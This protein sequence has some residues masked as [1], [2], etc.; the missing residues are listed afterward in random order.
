MQASP[1]FVPT[2]GICVP[3]KGRLWCNLPSCP[4]LDRFEKKR[5]VQKLFE[6][7]EFVG[8][9]PPS[10]FVSWK[11]YPNVDIAPLSPPQIVE[12]AAFLDNPEQWY[13]LPSSEI[14]GFRQQLFRS[15]KKV[16][17][18]SASNPTYDVAAIQEIAM[19]EKQVDLDVNLKDKP[20]LGS[21]FSDLFAPM[22]PSAAMEKFSFESNP[23]IPAK[24]D[25]LVSDTDAKSAVA[26]KELYTDGLP[27][28][29]L[30]KLLSAGTLGVKKNR[31][32]VPTRWSIVA[33]DDTVSKQLLEKVKYLPQLSEIRLFNSNYL[34]NNFWIM[35]LPNE[36]SFEM[37]ETW[38]PGGVWTPNAT[39]FHVAHD[40]EFF[41]GRKNYADNITGAYY[42]ARLA[43]CEYLRREK[44]Q[45]AAIVFREIGKGYD[46]PLGTWQIR[47]NVRHALQKKPLAFSDIDL[48]FAF[49][50]SKLV[51]PIETYRKKSVVYDALKHQKKILQ[52][53]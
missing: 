28:H 50:K 35:L 12:D 48:A 6:A 25:Y 41:S 21:S 1:S 46:V 23:S 5:A 49:L 36:W 9:S 53:V 15:N 14:L 26:I 43:V 45:A 7:K 38:M 42:S 29:V 18:H 8:S 3:C 32:F 2:P 24:V 52:W 40:F 31:K 47:E 10:V 17:V 19:S 27:V 22:G 13:G 51:V 30:Y 11:N 20:K 16:S 4:L 37:L 44:R 34:D 33:I 39:D